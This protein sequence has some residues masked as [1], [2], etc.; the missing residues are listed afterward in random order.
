RCRD[1]RHRA[2]RAAA[3]AVVADADRDWR[4]FLALDRLTVEIELAAANLDDIARKAD[5]PL[6][7]V[8]ILRRVAENDDVAA[9]WQMVEDA[10]LERRD[11]AEEAVAGIAVGPFRDREIV[12][13]V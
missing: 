2:R 1:D 10:A 6:D 12:A 11:F 9:L 4:Q 8:R 7:Q 13:D 5:H 3:R